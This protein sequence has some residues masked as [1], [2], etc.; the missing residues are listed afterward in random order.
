M[1]RVPPGK[2]LQRGV[3]AR[4]AEP[5]ALLLTVTFCGLL[6]TSNWAWY[7]PPPLFRSVPISAPDEV[8][9]ALSVALA[10]VLLAATVSNW[11][12]TR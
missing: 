5:P 10:L 12:E 2:W 1:R 3:T 7:C 4:L 9:Y 6:E 11:S 8:T